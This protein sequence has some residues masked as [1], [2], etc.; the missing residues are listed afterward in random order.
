MNVVTKIAFLNNMLGTT[1]AQF[2]EVEQNG[3]FM[4]IYNGCGACLAAL[5]S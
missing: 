4:I 1:Y 5:L 3:M 2:R